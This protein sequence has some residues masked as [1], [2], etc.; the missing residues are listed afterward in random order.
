[1]RR[2]KVK[3]SG[4]RLISGLTLIFAFLV[5]G[6]SSA[7]PT[8]APAATPTTALEAAPATAPT[9]APA[10]GP[11][12][13]TQAA[14]SVPVVEGGAAPTAAPTPTSP[15]V[16]SPQDANAHLR[17]AMHI[18]PNTGDVFT[19]AGNL[20]RYYWANVSDDLVHVKRDNFELVGLSGIE[21]WELTGEN[22][23][24]FNLRQGVKFHNGEPFNAEA[25]KLGID[26]AGNPRTGGPSFQYAGSMGAEVVDDSTF[27]VLCT[28][29]CPTLPVN[30]QFVG[31][32]APD[33][34]Q[35][36]PA[37]PETGK[38]SP[39]KTVSIGP[40]KFVEW[41]RAEF[42]TLE[43]Y[44][45]YAPV[46]GLEEAQ[47]SKA[48][49]DITY[50]WR[51]EAAVR[52][53]MLIAGEA[54]V[55]Y[56]LDL[57]DIDRVPATKVGGETSVFS[58]SLDN[59]WHPWLK[60]KK[61]RQALVHAVDCEALVESLFG[62]QTTCRGHIIFPG[63]LGATEENTTWYDYDPD[64]SRQLLEE[65]GYD[66]EEI[67]VFTETGRAIRKQLEVTESIAIYWQ[68]VG[69]NTKITVIDFNR[70]LEIWRSG[71]GSCEDPLKALEQGPCPGAHISRSILMM[72]P[73]NTSLDFARHLRYYINCESVVA[74]KCDPEVWQPLVAPALSAVGEERKKVMEELATKFHDD[75]MDIGFFDIPVVWGM[76]EDLVWEPRFDA[77]IRSNTMSFK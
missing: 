40:F 63:V 76:S 52:A 22:Q 53:A 54:D 47:A 27:D 60:Q 24:R 73:T 71:A 49:S 50:V 58:A 31:F 11:M 57:D 39:G 26:I 55:A 66:G 38:R 19:E 32:Q 3:L 65:I 9:T 75:V 45:D 64:L 5:L 17:V 15:P 69:I 10:T 35:S 46:P 16:S 43:R 2:D 20:Y 21:K 33:W 4:T 25:A 13:T 14:P 51:E 30:A 42:V 36:L 68:N 70:W 59:M 48:I 62:G 28:T 1:M 77:R 44:D 29:P 61:F 74:V 41:E 23:W 37:D 56:A 8:T 34:Y 12:A 6:C 67:Q 18:P 72:A 7:A